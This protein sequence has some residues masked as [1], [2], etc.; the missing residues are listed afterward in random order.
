MNAPHSPDFEIVAKGEDYALHVLTP[1]GREFIRATR[2]WLLVADG[3]ETSL[4]LNTT[5]A[6]KLAVDAYAN[7]LWIRYERQ[8]LTP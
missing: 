3:V 4:I 1:R 5:Q 6:M 7:D 8:E 2:T